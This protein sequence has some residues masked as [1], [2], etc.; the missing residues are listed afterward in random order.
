MDK[1]RIL[2][3]SSAFYPFNSPRSFRTTELAKEFARRGH[4]V[5][6]IT[7]SYPEHRQFQEE[8]AE[9]ESPEC[10]THFVIFLDVPLP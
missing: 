8:F 7:P 2:I 4:Q 1:K 6:V 10:N 9:N 3:I 5:K